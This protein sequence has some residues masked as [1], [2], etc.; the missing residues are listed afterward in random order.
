EPLVLADAEAPPV[1][2]QM[3]AEDLLDVPETVPEEAP[4]AIEVSPPEPQPAKAVAPPAP[5][6]KPDWHIDW[7]LL[8]AAIW[9]CGAVGW[10][11]LAGARLGRFRRVLSQAQPASPEL[12]REVEMLAE[13]F[14]VRCPTVRLVCGPLSPMI[15]VLGKTCCLLV[16]ANLLD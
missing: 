13:K 4:R 9:L 10:L 15:W 1:T 11:L 16:P 5:T 6:S 14:H 8:G 12:Q 2:E 3:P 7:P